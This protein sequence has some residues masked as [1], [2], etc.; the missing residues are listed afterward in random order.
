M[1]ERSFT[2]TD[3]AIVGLAGRYPGARDTDELWD[4]VR[5]GRSALTTIER[6]V[7]EQRG[8]PDTLLNH[9]HYVPVAGVLDD[10][11]QF[12]ARLF[13]YSPRDAA[14]LDP[15]QRHFLEVAWLAMADAGRI[16]TPLRTGIF[17]GCGMT[18]YFAQHLLPN[19]ALME[20]LGL[21]HVR[22]TGNDKDFL[23]TTVA[24]QLDLHGPA[25]SIQTACSTSLVAVH[26]ASQSLLA[27]EC[28]LAIAGGVSI[29]LPHGVGYRWREGEVLSRDGRCLPFD[30]EAS[31]TVITSGAGAAV[32]RRAVDAWED[33]DVVL[34]VIRGTAVNNDGRGKA[35]YVAPSVEGHAAVVRE[36]QQL[37]GVGAESVGLVE[38]HGTG[39]LIGDPIEFE[40]LTTAFRASTDR[41]SFCRLSSVKANVGHSDTAAGIAGL[42]SAVQALRHRTLPPLAGFRSPNPHL[43]L[44]ESPFVLSQRLDPWITDGSLRV[45]G[46]S[47]LGV[48]GT[49]AHVVLAEAPERSP[50]VESDR[51]FVLAMT[52]PTQAT[53]A[54][55]TTRLADSLARLEPPLA[56]V[57][58]SLTNGRGE[59]R[60]REAIVACDIDRAVAGLR[61]MSE[62]PHG[63]E[64]LTAA[65]ARVIFAFPG[66]GSQHPAMA[67]GLARQQ[68][69]FAASLGRG[70]DLLATTT[71]SDLRPLFDDSGGRDDLDLERPTIALPAIALVQ[72]AAVEMLA[73]WGVTPDAVLGHSMGEH[74]AAW[75]AGMLSLPELFTIVAARGRVLELAG[76]GAMLSVALD[77]AS[78][79]PRL[80]GTGAALAAVNGPRSCVVTGP[81]PD[82]ADLERR[83]CEE[84]VECVRLRLSSAAHSCLLDPVLH[85]WRENVAKIAHAEPL[86]PFISGLTGAVG[87]R[88]VLEQEYWVRQL[89]ETVQFSAALRTAA[90]HGAVLVDV[91]PG[92]SLVPHARSSD[93]TFHTITALMRHP[94]DTTHDGV[95][96]LRGAADL[97]TAGIGID[98]A[99]PHAQLGRR[100]RLPPPVLD[101]ERYW[102]EPPPAASVRSTGTEHRRETTNWFTAETWVPVEVRTADHTTEGVDIVFVEGGIG[103]SL[104]S[105][106]AD[107]GREVW[108]V[109]P[110]DRLGMTDDRSF[111]VD[112]SVPRHI[113]D[114]LRYLVGRGIR[115]DRFIHLWACAAASG[116]SATQRLADARRWQ[117]HVLWTARSAYENVIG[118]IELVVISAGTCLVDGRDGLDPAR[119][120]VTGAATVLPA[121]FEGLTLRLVDVPLESK[122][123]AV[124]RSRIDLVQRLVD[125]LE[126]RNTAERVALRSWGRFIPVERPPSF[127]RGHRTASAGAAIVT[128]ALGAMGHHIVR[129][130]AG[131]G[132]QMVLVSSPRGSDEAQRALAADVARSGG[133]AVWVAADLT[134]V[135]DVGRVVATARNTFGRVDALYHLAGALDDRLVVQRE[136]TVSDKVINAKAL[137][138]MLLAE[139]LTTDAPTTVA[140]FSSISSRLGLPGQA[141]YAGANAVLDVL[142]AAWRR[143]SPPTQAIAIDWGR[144]DVGGMDKSATT[145]EAHGPVTSLAR[146]HWLFSEHVVTGVGSVLPGAALVDLALAA[147]RRAEEALESIV[148]VAP[149]FPGDDVEIVAPRPGV[150]A[151]HAGPTRRLVAEASVVTAPATTLSNIDI[152]TI[153]QRCPRSVDPTPPQRDHLELGMRWRCVTEQHQGDGEALA[154]LLRPRGE[155]DDDFVLHPAVLDAAI[156]VGL[157]LVNSRTAP[158]H[159][160]V[161]IGSCWVGQQAPAAP[162]VHVVGTTTETGVELDL[163]FADFDG[164]V[165][166]T[167]RKVLL[168]ATGASSL[169]SRPAEQAGSSPSTGLRGINPSEGTG[170]LELA[171]QT[172]ETLLTV[173]PYRIDAWRDP[174]MPAPRQVTFPRT[175]PDI[176]KPNQSSVEEVLASVMANVLGIENMGP[177]DDFF[178]LGGHSLL[179][180]RLVRSV[181]ESL[182]MP[183]DLASLVAAPSPRALAASLSPSEH[184]EALPDVALSTLRHIVGIAPLGSEDPLFLIHG[185]GGNVANFRPLADQLPGRPVFGVQALGVDMTTPPHESLAEMAEAYVE[186][187][188]AVREEGPYILGGHS[189][190]GLLAL[191]VGR[192][193]LDAGQQVQAVVMLDTYRPGLV[194]N[195]FQAAADLPY[196]LFFGGRAATAR[197]L[198]RRARTLVAPLRTSP[199]ADDILTIEE[200][201]FSWMEDR[202]RTLQAEH[203]CRPYPGRVLLFRAT[204]PLARA[205][206][207]ASLGWEE[208]I[209]GRLTTIGVPGD[210]LTILQSPNVELLG[211]HLRRLL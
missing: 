4:L 176:T 170:A 158:L 65:E 10:V 54:A 19:E 145:T 76:R 153:L 147:V 114:V 190:G 169:S 37:A 183:L 126:A 188:R 189:I 162:W 2:E 201:Y 71:G 50:T 199:H 35:G 196:R 92:R 75:C 157:Q 108:T 9:P 106:L 59:H 23:A 181:R 112:P 198:R 36:A 155:D 49:N 193:L 172:D 21:F 206:Y 178:A 87:G 39:T 105:R 20:D 204:N 89:R 154:K 148:L 63:R 133:A 24:Y 28:D 142:A 119:A 121:E 98:L 96:A 103:R 5:E 128:G 85:E 74:T 44:D 180:L 34:A 179:G 139:A 68:P 51:P 16:R 113:D 107:L 146:D 182:G 177:D 69:A 29:Q 192:H 53:L 78:L 156:G 90:E 149:V 123:R 175:A 168:V 73:A 174:L 11:E 38:A 57:A 52:A 81:E 15:Q 125:E 83:L 79:V 118:D 86:V 151:I 135:A 91:G 41:R 173:S 111:V 40:A 137:S 30:G 164:Q 32:L 185:A 115:P 210:H 110:G 3:V 186:E 136:P 109:A 195:H 131:Q 25:I 167:L 61:G 140:L 202:Y 62:R 130:L 200:Q 64:P 160:P 127:R 102:A 31:G 161:T 60:L 143:S 184:R 203:R 120:L 134:N 6:K 67:A 152:S 26:L 208:L 124:W 187:I 95:L 144:W 12:A 205:A 27:G 117:D 42:I 100:T 18:A 22:H 191:E 97:W 17:A 207:P 84:D 163:T 48:G 72:V 141:D 197:R 1:G 99:E 129:H 45:A 138:A 104:A 8:V 209:T 194:R 66:G 211:A 55:T 82:V 94:A 93:A 165:V 7:L 14:L 70:L 159:V 132:A 56:D 80:A 58:Y 88:E 46:V 166:A 171:L 116:G 101:R 33:G 77:E 122:P 150:L 13:G 43:E 47:S